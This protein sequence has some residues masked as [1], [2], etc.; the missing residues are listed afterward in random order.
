ML[1]CMRVYE[2]TLN[3]NS[4]CIGEVL[5]HLRVLHGSISVPKGCAVITIHTCGIAL[6]NISS[7]FG[8]DSEEMQLLDQYRVD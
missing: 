7:G 4:Q 3:R 2:G 8:R 5:R 1:V 6:L